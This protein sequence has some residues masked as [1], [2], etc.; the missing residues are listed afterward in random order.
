MGGL[1]LP[2]GDEETSI[3]ASWEPIAENSSLMV[4]YSVF[5]FRELFFML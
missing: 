3:V 5:L 4:I 1:H 2:K